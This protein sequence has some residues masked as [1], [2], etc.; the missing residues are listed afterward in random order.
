MEKVVTVCHSSLMQKRKIGIP[1]RR[2][3]PEPIIGDGIV[4]VQ[5][6]RGYVAYV[7][8]ADYPLVAPYIW[9]ALPRG[10]TVYAIACVNGET[11]TMQDVIMQPEPGQEIDH[12]E[13]PCGLW[14]FRW[15]LRACTHQENMRN[16]RKAR[17]IRESMDQRVDEG[18]ERYGGSTASAP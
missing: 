4:G 18:E 14:N 7:D 9:R 11:K 6:T 3:I 17:A 1:H 10:H 15:N 5:L 13:N 16:N 2:K 12:F 8:A